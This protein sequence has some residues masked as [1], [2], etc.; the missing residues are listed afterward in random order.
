MKNSQCLSQLFFVF[1]KTDDRSFRPFYPELYPG[2]YYAFKL[3][4]FLALD[5]IW[6]YLLF[7]F[8]LLLL[9]GTTRGVYLQIDI[10]FTGRLYKSNILQRRQK[11]LIVSFQDMRASRGGT[12][13]SAP[14]PPHHSHPPPPP[15]RVT[16][17][18]FRL[19]F[20]LGR[21]LLKTVSY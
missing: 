10:K 21:F 19:F 4:S 11:C 13:Y 14:R 5:H 16:C 18:S 9:L 12:K 1:L 17:E 3:E 15:A 6:L 8:T 7:F 20:F 2:P